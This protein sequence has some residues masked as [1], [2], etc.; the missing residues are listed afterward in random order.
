MKDVYENCVCYIC[1]QHFGNRSDDGN[2]TPTLNRINNRIG[3]SL[4]NCNTCCKK[5]N[6]LK[7]DSDDL[8]MI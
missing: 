8:E 3:H 1:Y 6:G 5:F 4:L 7:S 2:I